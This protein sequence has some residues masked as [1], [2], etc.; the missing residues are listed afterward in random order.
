M[1]YAHVDIQQHNPFLAANCERKRR[2]G[3]KATRIVL[4]IATRYRISRMGK[5]SERGNRGCPCVA[6]AFFGG[7]RMFVDDVH[8]V[9]RVLQD[10]WPIVRAS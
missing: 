10:S 5:V 9:E 3:A 4:G 2:D 7:H 1:S 6:S 8:D